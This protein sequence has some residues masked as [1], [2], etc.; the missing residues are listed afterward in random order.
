MED[1]KKIQIAIDFVALHKANDILDWQPVG[2]DGD[3]KSLTIYHNLN[4]G[5]Y[6]DV[7]Y[8]FDEKGIENG[9]CIEISGFCT[10]SGNPIIFEWDAE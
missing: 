5:V 7:E 6:G 2:I 3:I 10:E 1:T 8:C 4:G 9:G